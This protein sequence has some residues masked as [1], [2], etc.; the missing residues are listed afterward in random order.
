MDSPWS[1][2]G[3]N[4]GVSSFSPSP[5]DLPNPV[6]EPG[7]PTLQTDSLPTE[8]S[9]KPQNSILWHL[10]NNFSIH[11]FW[12]FA[13]IF[14]MGEH[15]GYECWIPGLGRFPGGDNGNPLQYSCLENS[16][17][18]GPW[19]AT[20]HGVAKSQTQLACMWHDSWYGSNPSQL[21]KNTCTFM[22]YSGLNYEFKLFS[23]IDSKKEG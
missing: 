21:L 15:T 2:P 5:T 1:S 22:L 17:D 11:K 14:Q 3:Q 16:M 7:P 18:R 19:W 12:Y 8:L 6:I 4:T 23:K 13:R 10:K 20:V 9:E